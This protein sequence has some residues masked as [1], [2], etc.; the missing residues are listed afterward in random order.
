[1]SS[2]S[3]F[4]HG[5]VTL[6]CLFLT[7]CV[8]IAQLD[9]NQKFGKPEVVQR[10]V[11]ADSTW[12]KRFH[13]QVKPILDSRCS[14]CHGCYDAPCQLKLTSTAGIDRG[15]SQEVVYDGKRLVEADPSRLFVDASSTAAWRQRDFYP[16]LN[17]RGQSAF[18]NTEASVL[19]R[20]LDL[21]IQNPLPSGEILPERFTLGTYRQQE[22]TSIETFDSFSKEHPLWGMPYALPGL[23]REEFSILRDWIEAGSPMPQ[24]VV[25]PREY[26][27]RIDKWESF[28]NQ[29]NLKGKLVSRYIYEHLFLA[30]LYFDDL[31]ATVFL[32]LVRSS[33]PP[34]Q[35]IKIIATR[36]PYDDPGREQFY[37]RLQPVEATVLAKTHMPYVLGQERLAQWKQWFID[38]PYNVNELPAYTPEIASNPFLAFQQLPVNSRYRFLLD[39]A[40]F[41]INGFIKGPV[42]RGQVALN[43]IHDRFWVFFMDPDNI[44]DELS[45]QFLAEQSEHLGLPAEAESTLLPLSRWLQYSKRQKA[46]LK[47]KY[48]NANHLLDEKHNLTLDLIWDGEGNNANAALTI[49]RHFDSATV[50]KGLAGEMPETAWVIGY[51]VLERIHYLLVAGFDVYGNLGHQLLS[52]LYMDFL[53]MESEFNFLTLL[54]SKMH[55]AEWD[56]WYEGASG[57][58]NDYVKES[59][60]LFFHETDIA[61]KTDNPK[62]ELYQRLINKLNPVLSNN[63]LLQHPQVPK[64]HRHWL[65]QLAQIKGKSA[66][67]LPQTVVLSVENANGGR[68]QYTVIHNNAHSNISSLLREDSNRRPERDDVTVVRG[69]LGAYP[70]AFW[71]L[72]EQELPNL[73]KEVAGLTSESDYNTLMDK[74]GI[75]RTH[76]EF[77]QHSDT[78]H[79]LYQQAEPIDFGLLDYNRLE[80]R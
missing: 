68:H 39:E 57:E 75:R 19:Y 34:G 9:L 1:M 56:K 25:L 4:S 6:I 21:K 27:Q 76:A 48:Q 47:A 16:V 49:F 30:H 80:N 28:F 17:E 13:Q 53:R 65:E 40:H 74:Y 41:T 32:S 3:L 11:K 31:P 18:A 45:E 71:H 55:E 22:C 61:Y 72:N 37:Y 36:R 79:R 15:A 59:S 26:Q 54:P 2:F 69:I 70:S 51:P 29:S 35:P 77:W 52:R 38:A 67:I 60:K 63:Y 66:A 5:R 64:L 23:Y 24:A 42:C 33:T 50:V 7:G 73:V 44:E 8:A 78:L 62:R 58:V 43:V 14:V 10:A 46:Y 20:L 12:G